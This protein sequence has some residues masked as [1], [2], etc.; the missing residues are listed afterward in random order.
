MI[1]EVWSLG[2]Q[3]EHHLGTCWKYKLFSPAVCMFTSFS[4]GSDAHKV[5][6]TVQRQYTN[7][8]VYQNVSM[9]TRD[10]CQSIVGEKNTVQQRF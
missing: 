6:T 4:S 9:V 10:G 1:S 2:Q 3:H 7:L 5:R 8:N